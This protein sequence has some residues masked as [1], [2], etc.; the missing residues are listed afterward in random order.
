[1]SETTV[2][3]STRNMQERCFGLPQTSSEESLRDWIGL[4]IVERISVVMEEKFGGGA[5]EKGQRS[6]SV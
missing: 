2:P 1:M 5:E 6:I 3:D 4:A